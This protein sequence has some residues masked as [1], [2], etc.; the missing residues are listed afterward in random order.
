MTDKVKDCF[1]ITSSDDSALQVTSQL[2][3]KLV[4]SSCSN[5]YLLERSDQIMWRKRKP[6]SSRQIVI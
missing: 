2:S 3:I 1:N 4:K 5:G 6:I